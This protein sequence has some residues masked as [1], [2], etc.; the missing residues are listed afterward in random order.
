MLIRG[1]FSPQTH[2]LLAPLVPRLRDLLEEY[3]VAGGPNVRVEFVDPLENPELEQEAG[4]KYGIRPIPFQTSS[5]YQASVTNSYFDIL[6]Q[7]GD[8]FETL[9]F[10]DLIEVK[11]Q[12]EQTLDVELRNPE[13]DITRAIKKVFYTYQGGGEK[14]VCR[15]NQ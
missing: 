6:I 9:G 5:K 1:Y 7:Y 10:R 3:A 2:P 13:Y 4:Q 12:D 11:S 14:R 8:Q 15:G